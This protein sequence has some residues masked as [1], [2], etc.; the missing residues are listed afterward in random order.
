[1]VRVLATALH[2]SVGRGSCSTSD[3]SLRTARGRPL[4]RSRAWYSRMRVVIV[5]KFAHLTGG[6]DQH[7]LGLGDALVARGH[8][9]RFLSTADRRNVVDD[10][11]FVPVTVTHGSREGLPVHRQVGVFGKALWNPAAADAMRTLIEEMAPDVVHTH[12]LYPQLSVAPVV[13]AHRA[14]VPVVQTLHDFEMISASPIDARGGLWDPDE[15]RL[16]FKVLN[17]SIRPIHRRVHAPRVSAFVAVSRFVARVH[18]KYGMEASVLPN[19]VASSDKTLEELPSYDERD[20]IVF[21][22]RL[23]PEKGARDLVALAR[24]LPAISV[25]VVGTGD[26]ETELTAAAESLANL[27]IA[28]FVADPALREAVRRA[29]VIVIPSRCQDAG[30]LVPLEAMASATPVVAYAMGGLGEY[31]S[32]A[33]GGLVVPVDVAALATAAEEL[34]DDRAAWEAHARRGFAAIAEQHTPARYVERLE[35]V[36]ERASTS[37][38]QRR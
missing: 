25:T 24:R 23:R 15:T 20:G 12:K 27:H 16:R 14:G 2:G 34:H 36:Y 29:R 6:A 31:V 17:S 22:G 37:G 5:N 1:M 8:E 13:V 9:V 33:G 26:L 10:G 21:V 32:D 30:P 11:A 19:F 18:R 7:C 35:E 3:Y 4:V 28:G 38:G